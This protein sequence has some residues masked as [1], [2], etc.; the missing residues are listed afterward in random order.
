MSP[1][2]GVPAERTSLAWQ[3]TGISA[4][5]VGGLAL[6]A[7]AHDDSAPLLAGVAVLTAGCALFSG[8]A[9]RPSV[10]R[11]RGKPDSGR[12]S[13]WRRLL[14]A[15]TAAWALAVTGLLLVLA[16]LAAGQPDD[17]RVEDSLHPA[18]RIFHL[19]LL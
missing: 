4:A 9:V 13:P 3:R 1:E 18:A 7:A 6:A 17:V 10:D 5:A 14:A 15:A 2:Q 8:L 19:I 11:R 12:S 16:A